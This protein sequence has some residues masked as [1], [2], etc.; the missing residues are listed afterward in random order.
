[1]S[2]GWTKQS[3][4]SLKHNKRAS[5]IWK[6][7][8]DYFPDHFDGAAVTDLGCGYGDIAISALEAGAVPVMLV[9]RSWQF[10]QMAFQK[11]KDAGYSNKV[12]GYQLDITPEA[13]RNFAEN[14]DIGIMTSVLPYLDDPNEI[15]KAAT[16]FPTFIIECQYAGD[17]PG[18]DFLKSPIDM[19]DWL[20][21]CGFN[22][23]AIIGHTIVKDR[24]KRRDIWACRAT[25]QVF[26][27]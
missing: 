23:V 6:V 1:M 10:I 11:A 21:D 15:L 26:G 20:E 2:V 18:F 27:E 16:D 9:D 5:Q 8:H 25:D 3:R 19:A 4:L 13:V 24:N 22:E 17:G 14:S 12:V 7:I